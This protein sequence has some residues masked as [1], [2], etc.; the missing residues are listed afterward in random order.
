MQMKKLTVRLTTLAAG[1]LALLAI[2]PAATATA[3]TTSE[4]A[5]AKPKAIYPA[6]EVAKAQIKAA[7]K[8]AAAV[9]K[10]IILDFGGN[11]CGDCKT[12]D[13]LFHSEPN[14][15]LLKD[16]F[17]LVDVNIGMFDKNTDIA[18]KFGVPLKKGVPALAVLDTNGHVLF[19]QKQGEFEAMSRMDPSSVT[20]FLNHW[21][22]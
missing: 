16:N 14:E 4:P 15:T 2:W 21:K 22:Q 19:S 5:G 11:W 18:E 8:K 12:L 17:I 9:H 7:L 1:A 10:R 3:Q 20:E 13:K 6:P